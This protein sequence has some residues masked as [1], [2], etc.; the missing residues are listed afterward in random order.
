M[1]PPDCGMSAFTTL[2]P[3]LPYCPAFKALLGKIIFGIFTVCF[4]SYV[5]PLVSQPLATFL[6][7]D[8]KF[9]VC[10]CVDTH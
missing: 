10:L 9:A 1:E 5:T 3:F 6:H 2:R 8:L 4:L 7:P